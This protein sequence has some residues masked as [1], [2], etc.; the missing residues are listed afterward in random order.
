MPLQVV[1]IACDWGGAQPGGAAG[2]I[3]WYYLGL[4][5]K[6]LAWIEADHYLLRPA[7][8]L[9]VWLSTGSHV[10]ARRLE[11]WVGFA[12]EV[13]RQVSMLSLDRRTLFL[14][15]DHSWAGVILPV[16]AEKFP[17]IG[18]IWIDAHADLHNPA[19][20]PSG[21]LH[22]MALALATG[23]NRH[24]YHPIPEATWEI[25]ERQV[26]AAIPPQNLLF[27][28]LRSYEPPEMEII[29]SH[30][31]V[32]F[33]SEVLMKEGMEAAI[34]AAYALAERCGV[35]YVSF[36][37]DVWDPSFAPGTGSPAVGGLSIAHLRVFLDRV[38]SW[39]AT[40][41]VEITEINPLLDRENHTAMYA[42]GTVRSF[43]DGIEACSSL[44]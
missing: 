26:K 17:E 40:R 35:L 24:R 23:L 6:H 33:T 8:D 13:R 5:Y 3:S 18:V 42:Y 38:L 2:V 27:V 10:Y 11:S 32:H 7:D 31:I 19:T 1:G 37:V 43:I 12:E 39:S 21:N 15:G 28:G 9:I 14:T 34:Q 16:L 25:W 44:E 36:D 4:H 20:S 22:G 30:N 29:H 41:F